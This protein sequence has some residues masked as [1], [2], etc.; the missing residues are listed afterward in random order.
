MDSD[1]LLFLIERTIQSGKSDYNGMMKGLVKKY[2][3]YNEDKYLH[4]LHI[5]CDIHSVPT[6]QKCRMNQ[7]NYY[8]T[9]IRH[10]I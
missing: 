10:V 1:F 3:K 5:V 7:K 9:A 4:I 6:M 2:N 8:S